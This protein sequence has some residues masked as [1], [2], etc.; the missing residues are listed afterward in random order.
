MENRMK[1]IQSH[2]NKNVALRVIP[3]HFATNHS[4]INYYVDLTIMKSRRVRRK[5]LHR[6]LREITL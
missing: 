2:A 1:K 6:R 3:G 5:P 4:H